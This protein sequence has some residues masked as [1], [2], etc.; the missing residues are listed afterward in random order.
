MWSINM[1]FHAWLIDSKILVRIGDFHAKAKHIVKAEANFAFFFFGRDNF[2]SM[3]FGQSR[4][5]QHKAKCAQAL[6][7]L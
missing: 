2:C 3:N 4:N 6:G 1:N 7:L 5:I